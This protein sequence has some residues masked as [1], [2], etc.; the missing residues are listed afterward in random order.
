MGLI[1]Q[2][3]LWSILAWSS[4][5]SLCPTDPFCKAGI[6]KF[7]SDTLNILL[8]QRTL[9]QIFSFQVLDDQLSNVQK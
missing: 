6:Y 1:V 5:L 8:G 2:L 4:V 3:S 9:P 7:H